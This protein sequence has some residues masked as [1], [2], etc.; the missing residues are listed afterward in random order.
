MTKIAIAANMNSM[1][2]HLEK[3]GRPVTFFPGQEIG[4]I[5][6]EGENYHKVLRLRSFDIPAEVSD[7]CDVGLCGADWVAEKELELDLGLSVLN[8][9]EQFMYGREILTSAPRLELMIRQEDSIK[10]TA[11]LKPGIVLGEQPRLIKNYFEENGWKG[12]VAQMGQDGAPGKPKDFRKY[13]EENELM[14]I[15]IVHGKIASLVRS[16][17]GYGIGVNETNK[18]ITDN[19]LKVLDKLMDVP[20]LLVADPE[21]KLGQNLGREI[22]RLHRDLVDSYRKY[23]VESETS[24]IPEH[25]SSNGAHPYEV[26][27][28]YGR[29]SNIFVGKER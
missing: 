14:G 5:Y 22:M 4:T 10:S 9:D 13:C 27:K 2:F 24:G 17:A 29:Y 28:Q 15:R 19:G 18:T 8:K 20:V 3:A 26:G 23:F 1:L 21:A 25:L 7:S 16:G 6:G 11:K 12:K